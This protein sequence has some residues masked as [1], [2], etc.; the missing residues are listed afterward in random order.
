MSQGRSQW[1]RGLRCRSAAARLL[2]LWVRIP[3]GIWMSVFCDCC[4]LLGRGLCAELITCPEESY[5]LWCATECGL[6]TARMRRPWSSG[7]CCAPPPQNSPNQGI[8]S[9]AVV[10]LVKRRDFSSWY[11]AVSKHLAKIKNGILFW[12]KYFVL[13]E[14]V[15]RAEL[16]STGG[17]TGWGISRLNDLCLTLYC[18]G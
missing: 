2:R 14:H 15:T 3:L 11:S 10:S 6:E 16:L 17:S 8:A 9:G 1:P 18:C 13:T 4:V 12:F 5:R 7:G